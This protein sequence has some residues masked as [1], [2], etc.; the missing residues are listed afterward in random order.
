MLR[1]DLELTTGGKSTF[2]QANIQVQNDTL[3]KVLSYKYL[4][5]QDFFNYESQ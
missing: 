4:Q 3:S 5:N 1:L 2:L